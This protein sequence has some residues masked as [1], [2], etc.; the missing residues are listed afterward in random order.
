MAL[1]HLLYT[2]PF[3]NWGGVDW[4]ALY[5]RDLTIEKGK[6]HL[7]TSIIRPSSRIRQVYS[8]CCYIPI[9][10]FG[11]MSV[12]RHRVICHVDVDVDLRMRLSNDY[13]G[14]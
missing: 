4:T 13:C 11:D 2:M 1:S 6:E 9:L 7:R 8:T 3:Q 12:V 14:S 10:R 5:S